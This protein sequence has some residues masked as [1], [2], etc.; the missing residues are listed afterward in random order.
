MIN[1][2]ENTCVALATN[3]SGGWGE[4]HGFSTRAAAEQEALKE[5][6]AGCSVKEWACE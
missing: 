1:W 5:C 4:G 3:A 2:E 6:G